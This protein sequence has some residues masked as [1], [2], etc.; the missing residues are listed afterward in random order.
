MAGGGVPDQEADRP[1]LLGAQTL[2]AQ[3]IDDDPLGPHGV[4]RDGHVEVVSVR[5]KREVVRL[6]VRSG[7]P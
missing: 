6:R 3:P 4:E 2:R 7:A 1:S 5:M